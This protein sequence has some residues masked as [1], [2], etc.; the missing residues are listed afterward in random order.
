MKKGMFGAWTIMTLYLI[1]GSEA[2]DSCRRTFYIGDDSPLVIR[3]PNYPGRYPGRARCRWTVKPMYNTSRVGVTCTDV[4]SAGIR[5]GLPIG[6]FLRV[7]SSSF[8]RRVALNL[9]FT[10]CNNVPF[11]LEAEA[12]DQ[13]QL[14][15]VSDA[16]L[17]RRGFLCQAM[18]KVPAR[19][20]RQCG[21]VPE[22]TEKPP[23]SSPGQPSSTELNKD[24]PTTDMT[25]TST[26]NSSEPTVNGDDP[27]LNPEENSTERKPSQTTAMTGESSE[28]S[29][30][31][32]S[33]SDELPIEK[34]KDDYQISSQRNSS[35]STKSPFK[36]PIP[37]TVAP[38]T[39]LKKSSAIQPPQD[40]NHSTSEIFHNTSLH[41]EEKVEKHSDMSS[42][43]T[44][45]NK[46][47]NSL[48]SA[49]PSTGE[50]LQDNSASSLNDSGKNSG[51]DS[52]SPLE[53]KPEKLNYNFHTAEEF[54]INQSITQK[55][56]LL[57]PPSM[58]SLEAWKASSLDTITIDYPDESL[59]GNEPGETTDTV[60][61][62]S[63]DNIPL[64]EKIR[65]GAYKS[66]Q[67]LLGS[68]YEADT[69]NVDQESFDNVDDDN[70]TKRQGKIRNKIVNGQE[71]EPHE[72]PWAVFLR[73][74]ANGNPG[75]VCGGSII[76]Q[77]FI[78]T[79]AHCLEQ[80]EAI[81]IMIGYHD[82]EKP[83][84]H[85][86][87]VMAKRKIVH[88]SWRLRTVEHD[89]GMLEMEQS[90]QYNDHVQP[91]CLPARSQI[92]ETFAGMSGTLMGWGGHGPQFELSR[93]LRVVTERI[94]TN[95]QCQLRWLYL[96]TPLKMCVRGAQAH[97]PCGGDSGGILQVTS[98]SG[99]AIQVG[100]V[101]WGSQLG[102]DSRWP[103]G[104]TRV[105][106]YLD[107]I[108]ENSDVTIP[109]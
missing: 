53:T 71:A 76:S 44:S 105:T 109:T 22:R 81:K 49:Q 25:T 13:V 52:S 78:L 56:I 87:E 95:C 107:W 33:Q 41:T 16:V 40:E 68:K 91:I 69:T 28:R 35:M 4:D 10:H 72:Y 36:T 26:T 19:K 39:K 50:S 108:E 12:G 98:E 86:L 20:N 104:Y 11:H 65:K 24:Q 90:L 77:N 17:Q 97:S 5:I 84:V 79:A 54:K 2:Q 45:Q 73:I 38:D 100:I 103:S 67:N 31:T 62:K 70:S 3:S 55:F 21:I 43:A 32:S 102:C 7:T 18:V 48:T 59:S 94:L 83:S 82:L 37:S 64:A 96:V 34:I 15:F 14:D 106:G 61:G 57:P 23:S 99:H 101:S 9:D 47:V 6:D 42:G 92:G 29:N 88:P 1:T 93:R 63:S 51:V 74:V 66:L 58:Q 60:K 30:T 46:S 89:I 80:A 85:S 8:R 27:A 75:V